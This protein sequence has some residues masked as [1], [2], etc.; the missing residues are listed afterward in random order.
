MTRVLKRI[1]GL[2]FENFGWKVLSLA[3]A[4]LLWALVASEPQL[5]AFE[6]VPVEYKNLPPDLEISS[7]PATS[8]SLELQGPSGE[9]RELGDAGMRPSVILDM[10]GVVPGERTFPVSVTAHSLRLARGVRLVRAIPAQLRFDFDRREKREVP[11]HV[12]VTGEGY[13]GYMVATIRAN[14]DQLEIV[15]PAAR[16]S[17]IAFATTDAIDVSQV[18]GPAAFQVNA[19]VEDPYVRILSSPKVAVTVTMKKK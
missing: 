16:V 4:L 5:S 11:V 9:L 3:I 17:R 19:F 15:G 18:V 1:L 12:H 8:V 14:P 13:H 7:E 10:S 2:V 6:T